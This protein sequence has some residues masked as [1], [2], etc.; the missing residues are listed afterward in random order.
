MIQKNLAHGLM[1]D[2]GLSFLNYMMNRYFDVADIN[3]QFPFLRVP[4]W[5]SYDWE[6]GMYTKFY[7]ASEASYF[8]DFPIGWW[9]GFGEKMCN[10]IKDC[11]LQHGGSKYLYGVLMHELK[12]KWGKLVFE[13]D[14][15]GLHGDY[16][17]IGDVE[18]IIE[19]Y[20]KQSETTC[21]ECG[22]KG[23]IRAN[24]WIAPYCDKCSEK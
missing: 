18:K 9:I 3:E 19:K 17:T 21:I 10:E 24:T 4:I 14:Y 13:L 6:T 7:S 20:C 5:D 12:E 15:H 11:L 22:R 1:L 23:K 16:E 8:Y 2:R